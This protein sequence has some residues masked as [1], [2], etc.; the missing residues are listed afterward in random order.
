MYVI[1]YP[2]KGPAAANFPTYDYSGPALSTVNGSYLIQRYIKG[3][4]Y[5]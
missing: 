5:L 1:L 2:F 3:L 4:A